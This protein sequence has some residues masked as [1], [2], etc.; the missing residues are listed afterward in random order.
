VRK[1]EEDGLPSQMDV[2]RILSAFLRFTD[3]LTQTRCGDGKRRFKKL[4]RVLWADPMEDA[5]P[6]VYE[7]DAE[8]RGWRYYVPTQI[9]FLHRGII[10]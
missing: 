8:V 5:A 9:R 2:C 6:R 1:K 10:L 7:R 4:R 3:T